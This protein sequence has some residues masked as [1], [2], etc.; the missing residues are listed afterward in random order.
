MLIY[1]LKYQNKESG[2]ILKNEAAEPHLE[3]CQISI[4]GRFCKNATAKSFI[5]DV[6]YGCKYTTEVVQ[7]SK[8]NLKWMNTKMLEKTVHFLNVDFA[9][10]YFY[11]GI[12]QDIRSSSSHMYYYIVVLKNLAKLTEMH[13]HRSLFSTWNLQLYR[14]GDVDIYRFLWVL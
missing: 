14:K 8:I 5:I 10:L 13:L 11:V 4:M 1:S 6:W 9:E 7:D 3:P 2:K 12:S